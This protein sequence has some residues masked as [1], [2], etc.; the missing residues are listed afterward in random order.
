[1]GDYRA[2]WTELNAQLDARRKE[3]SL[4]LAE[5]IS[6]RV[7]DV[8]AARQ[9]ALDEITT[10]I[11]STSQDPVARELSNKT[12]DAMAKVVVPMAAA[13]NLLTKD[14]AATL[15]DWL[16][17]CSTQDSKFFKS[18]DAMGLGD[19]RDE[20]LEI[21][22]GLDDLIKI[23][24]AK[25]SRMSEEN[26]RL[27]QIEQAASSELNKIVQRALADG[28]DATGKVGVYSQKVL[29][30]FMKFGDFVGD[31]V[32]YLA[33]EAGVPESVAKLIPK[34]S[35][36]GKDTFQGAKDLGIPAGDVSKALAFLAR[37]PG[38]AVTETLQKVGGSEFEMLCGA[39]VLYYKNVVPTL[40]AEY[41]RQIDVYQAALP[42]QGSVLVSLSQTRADVDAFL[43][44]AGMEKLQA[45][46][47]K[48]LRALDDWVNGQPTPG[49]N[50]DAAEFRVQAKGMFDA[51][52][53]NATRSFEEFVRANKG[54]FVGTIEK[55]TETALL[56]TD[57]WIDRT[58]GIA[59]LGMDARLKEWRENT[60]A[61]TDKFD[62]ASQ[63]VRQQLI[64]LPIGLQEKLL[65][66]FD[67]V[68][69][70]MRDKLGAAI[71]PSVA[72]LE[73]AAPAVASDQITRDL[74]RSRL[75]ERL[76]A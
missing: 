70:S 19:I 17:A 57:I 76:Y 2:R 4:P 45:L 32:V 1:M 66:R 25:W 47:E 3:I 64:G 14:D 74:D 9:A 43:K 27:E 71:Q 13:C 55:E 62:S 41:R 6:R 39:L 72:A 50:A 38:M 11:R 10:T 31:A 30:P 22:K 18:L 29:E 24:D 42:N 52:F 75:R 61:I 67:E 59:N 7:A 68:F 44:N 53:N 23:L 15:E 56:W 49:L 40:V 73:Q 35:L 63:Q 12:Q 69:S 51:R 8:G 65:R 54:R 28:T 5:G 21:R 46:Y 20:M 16:E 37:D 34:I 58:R 48:A 26:Q 36:I 33:I 60:L